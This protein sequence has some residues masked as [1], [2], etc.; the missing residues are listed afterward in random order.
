MISLEKPI[1]N[2]NIYNE[3]IIYDVDLIKYIKQYYDIDNI[4]DQ[5]FVYDT[6]TIIDDDD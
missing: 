1:S 2:K 3:S 6:I 5:P 4:Y